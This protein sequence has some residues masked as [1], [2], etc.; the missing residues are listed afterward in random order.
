MDGLVDSFC[1]ILN[2]IAAFWSTGY[3]NSSL[4]PSFTKYQLWQLH[5]KKLTSSFLHY[6]LVTHTHTQSQSQSV[7]LLSTAWTL[8]LL[9]HT[10]QLSLTWLQSRTTIALCVYTPAP[11]PSSCQI[12]IVHLYLVSCL[13]V[14]WICPPLYPEVL[15]CIFFFFVFL[16]SVFLF[17]TTLVG[18]VSRGSFQPD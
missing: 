13:L 8:Q 11:H 6:F 9:T 3:M 1:L 17:S 4:S 7:I 10:H 18:L 12:V 5:C 2:S 16:E 15:R 14:P